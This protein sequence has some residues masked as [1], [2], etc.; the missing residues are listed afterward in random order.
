MNNSR[1]FHLLQLVT[2]K[3][4]YNIYNGTPCP[5]Y[6]TPHGHNLPNGTPQQDKKQSN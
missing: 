4:M 1:N 6:S 3:V 5:Q 2:E